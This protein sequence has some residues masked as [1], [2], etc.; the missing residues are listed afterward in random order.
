MGFVNER[1]VVVWKIVQ[2]AVRRL[3][4]AAPIDMPG[5]VFNAGTETDLFHHF[6]VIGGAHA[7]ALCF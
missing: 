6:N 3:S 5:I 4:F 2:K 7:N 1:Q